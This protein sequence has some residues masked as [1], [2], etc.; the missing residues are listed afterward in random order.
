MS[1][2]NPKGIPVMIGGVERHFLF[3]LNAIDDIQDHF[4][5]PLSEVVQQFT[6]KE[7]AYKTMR[8]V[9]MVLIND[10]A[11]RERAAGREGYEILT[12]QEVGWLITLK[13]EGEVALAILKAYGYS[14]PE[15]EDENP[16]RESGQ[17]M[18]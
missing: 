7:Q 9:A 2:L 4:E 15:S 18:E 10:E 5:K 12:E 6:E 17:T 8:Y 13:N 3:T 11:E 1:D 16:N 14:L